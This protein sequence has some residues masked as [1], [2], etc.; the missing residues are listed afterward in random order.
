MDVL[1]PRID[2]ERLSVGSNATLLPIAVCA[3]VGYIACQFESS[4]IFSV[5]AVLMWGVARSRLHAYLYIVIYT[6]FSTWVVVPAII[7]YLSW[8]PVHALLFWCIGMPLAMLPWALLY[9]LSLIHI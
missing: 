8:H 4:Y 1:A 9:R 2:S 7:D 3:V 6:G 5:Y